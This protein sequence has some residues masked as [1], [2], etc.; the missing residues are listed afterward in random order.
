MKSGTL[1]GHCLV[2]GWRW[3]I[4]GAIRAVTTA[5]EPGEI[6]CHISK[7]R[8]YRFPVGQ[9]LRN[10]NTT[11]RSVSRWKLSEHFFWRFCRKGSFFQ[12]NQKFLKH[13]NVL[14]LQL[15]AITLQLLQIAR[16]S[17]PIL[18]GISSFFFYRWNQF[19]VIPWAIHS[20]QETSSNFLRRPTRI[21]NTA[22]N[23]DITQSQAAN[24][25]R[26]TWH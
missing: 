25:H 6:F 12:K 16:N 1:W 26:V 17:L 7:A 2:G 10:L 8:F 14:R 9:I 13:F 11:R 3:Q 23:A 4:L 20:V 5:G 18:Y 22:D 19:K 21:D 15:A 24:H